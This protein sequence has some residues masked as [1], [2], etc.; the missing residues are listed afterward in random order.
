MNLCVLA[1]LLREPTLLKKSIEFQGNHRN[2][3]V[4]LIT[5]FKAILKHLKTG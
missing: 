1:A 4:I 2:A 5:G 3:K